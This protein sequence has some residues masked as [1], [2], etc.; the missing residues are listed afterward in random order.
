MAYFGYPKAQEAD[1]RRAVQASLELQPAIADLSREWEAAL[2]IRLQLR[3]AVHTG[4]VVAGDISF[5]AVTERL[6][7]I[8]S[9]TNIAARLQEAGEP[10]CATISRA[11]YNLVHRAFACTALGTHAL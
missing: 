7:V 10:G 9:T 11:T 3:I 5:D 4:R 8:G 2:G 6:A 1:A